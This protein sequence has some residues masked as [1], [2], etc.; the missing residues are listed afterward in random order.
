MRL[1][2][3]LGDVVANLIVG[4]LAACAVAALFGPAWPQLP[5]MLAGML[6]GTVIAVPLALLLGIC[7]GAF[8][9]MLPSMLS[10]MVAGMAAA[11]TATRAPLSVADAALIGAALGLLCLTF[12]YGANAL[13]RGEV[14]R[15]TQ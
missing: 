14:R 15:W 9:V 5:A 2:F 3:V 10:G 12:S 13:L 11:M 1:Y 7:F 6:L 8:E 4:A